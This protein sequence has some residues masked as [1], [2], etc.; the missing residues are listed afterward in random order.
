M[1]IGRCQSTREACSSLRDEYQR[2]ALAECREGL[3]PEQCEAQRKA[4][5]QLTAAGECA[6]QDHA[7][8]H[9]RRDEP[10]APHPVCAPTPKLC[11][12]MRDAVL[13]YGGENKM[14]VE[15]ACAI[16]GSLR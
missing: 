5:A 2:A 8:C 10:D 7:W 12:D 9:L 3:A 11:A 1:Q 4:S 13:K 6:S 14:H 15:S 16:D